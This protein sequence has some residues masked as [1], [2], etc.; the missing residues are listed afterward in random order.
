MKPQVNTPLTHKSSEFYAA[1]GWV[2]VCEELPASKS[3]SLNPVLP[4][5]SKFK[6]TTGHSLLV[7][8]NDGH[9]NA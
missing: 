3:Q 1:E 7:S 8:K 6:S 5:A 9:Y 4:T 2:V